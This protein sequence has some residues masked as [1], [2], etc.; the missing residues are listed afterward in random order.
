MKYLGEQVEKEK[1]AERE[2]EKLIDAEVL[3]H[4]LESFDSLFSSF[5]PSIM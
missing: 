3:N 1:E 2:L 5:P 4:D